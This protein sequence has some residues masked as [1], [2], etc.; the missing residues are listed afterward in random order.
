MTLGPRSGALPF[1]SMWLMVDVA[2]PARWT[3]SPRAAW[4]YANVPTRA[5]AEATGNGRAP[6]EMLERMAAGGHPFEVESVTITRASTSTTGTPISRRQRLGGAVSARRPVIGAARLVSA[7]DEQSHVLLQALIAADHCRRQCVDMTKD[8]RPWVC[9]HNVAGIALA[10]RGHR[11]GTAGALVDDEQQFASL[12]PGCRCTICYARARLGRPRLPSPSTYSTRFSWMGPLTRSARA[13]RAPRPEPGTSCSCHRG[14]RGRRCCPARRYAELRRG[15]GA[16]RPVDAAE[17]RRFG[18]PMAVGKI[19]REC[20]L[21]RATGRRSARSA[22]ADC[23][24]IRPCPI[25]VR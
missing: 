24:R 23:R 8:E 10:Q 2:V 22:R 17:A 11:P 4:R 9:R 25:R 16:T 19:V 3:S 13:G 18:G 6:A 21:A 1:S 5:R 20:R 14:L 15:A 12:A 7:G